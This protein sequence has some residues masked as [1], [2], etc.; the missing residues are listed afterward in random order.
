[1]RKII[2]CI[3]GL[4]VGVTL[5]STQALGQ[6]EGKGKRVIEPFDYK[7]I[8]LADGPVLAQVTEVRKYYL[9][10]PNDDLL[11]GFR[12]RAGKDAPGADM[13]GW[14]SGDVFHI[15]G[16]IVSGLS[17]MYAGTGDEAC[18]DKVNTLLVEWGKCI[19]PDGYFFYSDKP[20]ARHYIYEKTI[21]GLVDAYVYCGNKDALKYLSQI[22]DWAIKN[23]PRGRG[24]G[25]NGT[26]WYTLSENLYRAFLVTGDV[27]YRDFAQVWEYTSYWDLYAKKA[28]IPEG[29]H[30]YSHVNTLSGAGAAY[31]VKGEDHY[32]ETLK[33]ASAYI[34]D[35][36]SFV[37]GG[38]GPDEQLCSRRTLPDRL[39]STHNTF[40]TQCGSW[41]IFKV[42]K[43]LAGFTGD[44]R[45][46]D[47][48]ERVAINGVGASIPTSPNGR[49][50][51]YSD[52]NMHGGSKFLADGWTCCAGTRPQAVADYYDLIYFKDA[53]SLYVNLF[54]PSTV[55]WNHADTD[56]T[57][58]QATGFPQTDE[59]ELTVHAAKPVECTL[60]V[61]VPNWLAGAMTAKLN[62]QDVPVQAD[63]LHWARFH[64]TWTQGDKLTIK[65]PMELRVSRLSDAAYPAAVQYGPVA[66]AFRAGA[67]GLLRKFDADHPAQ[68]LKRDPAAALTWTLAAEP[69]VLLQ[70]FYAYKQGEQYFLYLQ[71][72]LPDRISIQGI[73]FTGH[74]GDGVH[75]RYTSEIGATA[76]AE[77]TGTSI[78]WLGQ[79]FDDAG[80]AEVA[81]DGKVVETVDQYGPVRNKPFTHECKGLAP[82][83][84]TIRL[85][86]MEEKT[87]K[88][89]DRYVNVEGFEVPPKN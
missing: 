36:L 30:A 8:T 13:G 56:I 10:I 24:M 55:K 54:I 22:T 42:G 78:R 67:T 88:S 79:E 45:Y 63:P 23:L 7:G 17:R 84:H 60:A 19:A 51:Y 33:N 61:R 3:I 25:D 39:L 5:G 41:A 76:E 71:P 57:V 1:M 16:Q 73:K 77:F 38:F 21:C 62:G 26:E 9:A 50:M 81:I 66:L 34:Q 70:P 31:W 37:T 58:A 49:V 83:K 74:W 4:I 6:A 72:G 46:G 65:L 12:K 53:D 29:L 48:I 87:A 15:F 82:G 14:Y 68:S 44:A 52:Y 20:N 59:T 43:Y 69:S 32:L 89:R 75:M 18:R 28:P 85:R 47:W 64:R 80:R 27:K 40:E 2:W 86:V 11:K 35:N